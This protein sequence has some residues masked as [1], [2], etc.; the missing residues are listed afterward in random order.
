[1]RKMA[2]APLVLLSALVLS[3]CDGAASDDEPALPAT[4]DELLV[5]DLPLGEV[6]PGELKADSFGSALT[7]KP[8]PALDALPN[9]EIV[10]SLDGATLH[11]FDRSTGYDEVFPIGGGKI[12]KGVSLTPTSLAQ[13]GQV[14]YARLEQPAVKE[15]GAAKQLW[16]WNYSCKIWW[17]D[18]D[19]GGKLVPVFAGL[20]FIRLE[21]PS[22]TAYGIHG[23]IDQ[24]TLPS[25]GRLKRGFVSHGCMRMEAADLLEV[26]ARAL[27]H[28]VPVRI[29]QAPE[30]RADGTFVE[31]ADRWLGAP[32][33]TDAECAFDG[34]SCRPNPY[35]GHGVC[36]RACTKTCPDRWGYPT[37]FCVDDPEDDAEGVCVLKGVAQNNYCKA[38]AGQLFD[39]GTPRH[40]QPSVTADVCTLGSEG[41]I[42]QPCWTDADCVLSGGACDLADSGEGKPGVCTVSCTQYCPDKTGYASTFC[43]AGDQGGQCAQRCTLTDECP[44]GYTCTPNVPRFGQPSVK[45]AVCQ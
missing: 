15:T 32:C 42:G 29:Q 6:D 7:C 19:N 34:G 23:P 33:G 18:T 17:K 2:L 22:P 12:E 27:G 8:I 10:I 39:P 28:K 36:T 25:G 1:M 35:T 5:D 26:Y 45:K 31:V 30:R 3:G 21:G 40:N 16:A 11:L 44:T 24:Y 9:P 37:S 20:P 41:W 13:P 14:F 38:Y 43:V 4:G